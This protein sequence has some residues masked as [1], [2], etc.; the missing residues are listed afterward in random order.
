MCGLAVLSACGPAKQ[1]A[2]PIVIPIGAALDRTGTAATPS[3]LDAIN[4]AV[5]HANAGLTASKNEQLGRIQ[6][7]LKVTDHQNNTTVA[8]A[9][10]SDLVKVDGAKIVVIQQ[11]PISIAVNALNYDADATKHLDVALVCGNCV[12]PALNNPNAV[13]SNPLL[14]A[15]SRDEANWF[16]RSVMNNTK[17]AELVLRLVTAIAPNG[18]L[19]GDGHFKVGVYA[20]NDQGL[21]AFRTNIANAAKAIDANAIIEDKVQFPFNLDVNTYKFS[22][23]M[24]KLVDDQLCT[25]YDSA[26]G[27]CALDAAS[28]AALP[29]VLVELTPSGIAASATK[30]FLDTGS[31]AKF[32]H[33]VNFRNANTLEVL[34]D[35]AN[36]QEGTSPV[37]FENNESGTLFREAILA[38][39]GN[40][41]AIQDSNFYD[42]AMLSMLAT[43]VAVRDHAL[44]DPTAVTGAQIRDALLQLSA[45]TGTAVKTG[46]EAFAAAVNAIAS[47]EAVNYDGASGPVDFDAAGDV[48]NRVA[49]WKVEGRTF[50][51]KA[52]YD[53]VANTSCPKL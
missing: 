27:T 50:V 4:L 3:W 7:E 17:D 1:E 21:N 24:A 43:L 51:D 19:N 39:T 8:P 52:L 45:P 6:F 25:S 13:N 38:E 22:Q 18:D 46:P 23:D 36:G 44:D 15:G 31:P 10:V 14:Q 11:A 33:M 30:A 47:G 20:S 2:P 35:S 5:K 53:C 40:E 32:L 48:R 49:Q 28:P 16:F 9:K 29:D 42:G 37:L 26:A 34:G 12:L 41:P